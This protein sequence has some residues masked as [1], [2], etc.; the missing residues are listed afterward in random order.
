VS[1]YAETLLGFPTD[2][3]LADPEFFWNQIHPDEREAT[4]K[5]CVEATMR[6]ED[7]SLEYRMRTADGRTVWIRDHVR[8][9]PAADGGPPR[10]VG[11]MVDMTEER[12]T[13]IERE[14]IGQVSRLLIEAA[15]IAEIYRELPRLLVRCTGFP[16]V[17]I[18]L[19]RKG[20][21][22]LWCVGAALAE[23]LS[24][25]QAPGLHALV[26]LPFA[27]T[28]SSEAIVKGVSVVVHDAA[29]T[30]PVAHPYMHGM[31]YD[32]IVSVPLMNGEVAI[33]AISFV[34]RERTNVEP[35]TLRTLEIIAS[36]LAHQM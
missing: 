7:H 19:G 29:R 11:V 32:T 30:R 3:W 15:S 25:E 14:S 21:A 27:Q 12:R 33:G 5:S 6:G 1:A 23:G 20:D 10:L 17:G 36:L 16:I 13:Q 24:P 4:R 35:S 28:V 9:W 34:S 22:D 2:R 8:V 18:V 26:H 31:V